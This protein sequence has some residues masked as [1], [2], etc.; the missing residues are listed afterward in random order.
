VL[1]GAVKTRIR[2]KA[3]KAKQNKPAV[4]SSKVAAAAETKAVAA[5]VNK[6]AATAVAVAAKAAV[7][8]PSN[9]WRLGK[10]ALASLQDVVFIEVVRSGIE[11]WRYKLHKE[12]DRATGLFCYCLFGNPGL[13]IV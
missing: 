5:V 6:A 3:D 4:T 8:V 1:A 11:P 10:T 12:K 7:A 13:E 2:V 9:E